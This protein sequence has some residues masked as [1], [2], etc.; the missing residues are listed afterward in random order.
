MAKLPQV[1]GRH[2]IGAL[3]KSGWY[4]H[5]TRGSHVILKNDDIPGS[6]VTV[7]VH[8]RPLKPYVLASILKAAGL[9][10]AE[11]NDLL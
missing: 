8:P 7:P 10:V 11:M 3:E 1:N 4:V 2:V 6:R 9:T 5:R